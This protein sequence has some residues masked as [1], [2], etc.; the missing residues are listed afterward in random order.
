MTLVYPETPNVSDVEDANMASRYAIIIVSVDLIMMTRKREEKLHFSRFI[1]LLFR[2]YD[3]GV[4]LR[5]ASFLGN[6]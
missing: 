2:L 4:T 3:F 5:N 1:T 6:Y